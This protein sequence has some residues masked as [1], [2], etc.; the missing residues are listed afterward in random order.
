MKTT[1]TTTT[2]M[3]INNNKLFYDCQFS[4]YEQYKNCWTFQKNI[5]VREKVHKKS[6]GKKKVTTMLFS[7]IF[8]NMQHCM[9]MAFYESGATIIIKKWRKN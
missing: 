6:I 3:C 2:S 5:N 7:W 1:Q 4:V 8:N 9:F